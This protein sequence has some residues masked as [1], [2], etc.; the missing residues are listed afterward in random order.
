MNLRLLSTSVALC[1]ILTFAAPVVSYAQE[2]GDAAATQA[3]EANAELA[4]SIKRIESRL[5]ALERMV[6]GESK[7]SGSTMLA[8]HEGRLQALE[9][10]SSKVYGIAEEVGNAV[11]VLAKKVDLIASDI[12]LRLTDIETAI[13]KGGTI[14]NRASNVPT[15]PTGSRA[16]PKGETVPVPDG[17]DADE[18]YKEAYGYM[19]KGSFPTAQ[20]WFDAFTKRFP[21]HDKAQNAYYW[22]GEV[23]LVQQDPQSA[24]VAFGQAVKGFPTGERT[25]DALLK[26]G[27]AF[28]EIGKENLAKTTW[29]KLARDFPDSGAAASAEKRL[30]GLN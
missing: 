18:L 15:V 24:L 21:E 8:D 2:E 17:I 13:Q 26:M 28:Q 1:T 10:E 6:L 3:A 16:E 30:E 12:D 19:K 5:I 27:V 20:A 7:V 25:P 4:Q 23:Y 11:E 29:E 14:S 9:V 22:L